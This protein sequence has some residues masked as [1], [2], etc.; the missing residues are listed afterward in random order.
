MTTEDLQGILP[1]EDESKQNHE[2]MGIIKP[3]EEKR[4][5]IREQHWFGCTQSN[6]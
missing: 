4:Q 1:T 6:P 5:V 2:R 3:Q